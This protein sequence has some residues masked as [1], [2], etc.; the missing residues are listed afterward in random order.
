MWRGHHPSC[1]NYCALFWLFDG[2]LCSDSYWV[3]WR[4][5]H[6]LAVDFDSLCFFYLLGSTAITTGMPQRN[7]KNASS[8]MLAST[9]FYGS[10]LL[11]WLGVHNVARVIF[12]D[13]ICWPCDT[14]LL[15]EA[16]VQ[17]PRPAILYDHACTKVR[18]PGC[19]RCIVS[20]LS[21]LLTRYNARLLVKTNTG[22]C[23]IRCSFS[24]S[25]VSTVW[26][27]AFSAYLQVMVKT[28]VCCLFPPDHMPEGHPFLEDTKE[29]F[30]IVNKISREVCLLDMNFAWSGFLRPSAL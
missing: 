29:T 18:C 28:C 2:P 27:E 14:V 15:K 19:S 1:D 21:S 5:Q 23:D 17:G 30:D 20:P 9:G 3:V 11:V 25:S 12:S 24:G 22:S 6:P 7:W 8:L 4:D 16:R 26:S 13:C 10:V